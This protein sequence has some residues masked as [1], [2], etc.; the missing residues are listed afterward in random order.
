[1]VREVCCCDGA[2]G[3]CGWGLWVGFVD[4]V[5][6]N[7]L[8][9][10]H[11]KPTTYRRLIFAFAN[12]CDVAAGDIH[13]SS[14][15]AHDFVNPLVQS[16]FQRICCGVHFSLRKDHGQRHRFLQ[17]GTPLWHPND[18]LRHHILLPILL[19]ESVAAS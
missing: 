6:C 1:M 18:V 7:I 13:S 9:V 19:K 11:L 17:R 12:K 5:K 3:V 10:L 4:G 14:V 15:I 16:Y 8:L 2:C